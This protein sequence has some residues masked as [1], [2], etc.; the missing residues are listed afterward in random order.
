MNDAVSEIDG[1]VNMLDKGK[2]LV[3]H[4]HHS[5]RSSQLLHIQQRKLGRKEHSLIMSVATR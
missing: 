5:I 3:L 2:N 1:I 4:N